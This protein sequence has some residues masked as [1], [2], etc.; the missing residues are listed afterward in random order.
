MK[1]IALLTQIIPHS[2][3]ICKNADALNKF[4][5]MNFLFFLQWLSEKDRDI[6]SWVQR[7]SAAGR[8]FEWK[9][10]TR[11]LPLTMKASQAVRGGIPSCRI[12]NKP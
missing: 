4:S 6:F 3:G 1:K 10:S 8:E 9:I 11:S 12:I 2:N 7:D 5:S